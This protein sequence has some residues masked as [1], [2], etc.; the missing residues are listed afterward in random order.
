MRKIIVRLFLCLF[1]TAVSWSQTIEIKCRITD[2][3][4]VLLLVRGADWSDTI[5]T[6]N[7][8]INHSIRLPHPQ[9]LNLAFIK[10]AQSIKAMLKGNERGVRSI[11]DGISREVFADSGSI[12]LEADFAQLSQ[13]RLEMD[14]PALH[15]VYRQ[16]WKRFNPLVKMARTII[17]SSYTAKK[18]TEATGI[19]QSLY[20]RVEEL[21]QDVAWQ[22][23]MEQ[24]ND[25]VGA[26]ILYRYG[27]SIDTARMV[28]AYHSFPAW[29]KKSVYLKNIQEKIQ[30]FTAVQKG[31]KAPELLLTTPE[32]N[33]ISLSDLRG[34]YLV[35]DFWGSWCQPCIAGFP[36]MRTYYDRYKDKL[37]I[38]GIACNDTDSAWKAAIVQHGLNWIQT[39]EGEG[40][41]SAVRRYNVE[42]FPTKILIDPNGIIMDIFIGERASFYQELEKLFR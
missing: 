30:A 24:N 28:K 17:D 3:D 22:F 32:G 36:T 26:Y 2:V 37:N 41:A 31:Q 27:R 34:K 29:I 40:E 6:T 14:K 15:D 18:G 39:K 8:R 12:R 33:R 21:E 42:A 16:F 9:L 7:G 20:K 38:L 5:M 11:T 35:L 19:Y 1:P 13:A 25:L 10:H 4:T 23:A